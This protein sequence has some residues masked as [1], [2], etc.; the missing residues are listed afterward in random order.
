MNNPTRRKRSPPNP[1]T[2][3]NRGFDYA[4]AQRDEQ[5]TY[6]QIHPTQP[7]HHHPHS[8]LTLTLTLLF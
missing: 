5:P 1:T 8:L 2:P 6:E 4:D 3:I 7:N